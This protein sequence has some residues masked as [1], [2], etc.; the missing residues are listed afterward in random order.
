MLSPATIDLM[1]IVGVYGSVFV[2]S[3]TSVFRSMNVSVPE[4]VVST[5]AC[6]AHQ[7]RS[8]FTHGL[9]GSRQRVF[10][11]PPQANSPFTHALDAPMLVPAIRLRMFVWTRLECGLVK[12]L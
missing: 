7:T 2:S 12:R 3:R 4:E 9:A 5:G 11:A 8:T 10:W 6:A 1:S